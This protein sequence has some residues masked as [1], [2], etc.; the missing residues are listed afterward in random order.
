MVTEC[1]LSLRCTVRS[2]KHPV[3]FQ[4]VWD[5]SRWIKTSA[6][7]EVKGPSTQPHPKPHLP[8]QVGWVSSNFVHSQWK[9]SVTS[10]ESRPNPFAEEREGQPFESHV[11]YWLPW[12][13]HV[14]VDDPPFDH[15]NNVQDK[16]CSRQWVG[17]VVRCHTH[18]CIWNVRIKWSQLTSSSK[19]TANERMWSLKRIVNL[20]TEHCFSVDYA[21]RTINNR[22][23]YNKHP[24]FGII[25]TS[26]CVS[27]MLLYRDVCITSPCS[28]HLGLSLTQPSSKG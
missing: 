11:S 21:K 23:H 4:T 5:N 10:G 26:L 19:T 8:S 28:W 16:I 22:V 18:H 6:V 13:V 1:A 7:N 17:Y 24:K 25:R 14:V 2:I 27:G 20:E 15:A 12:S 9:N 3:L